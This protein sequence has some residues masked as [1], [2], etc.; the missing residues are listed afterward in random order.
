MILS[1]VPLIVI[2]APSAVLLVGLVTLAITIFLSSTVKMLVFSVVVVP[3]TVRF[4]FTTK[5]PPRLTVLEDIVGYNPIVL[6]FEFITIAF[7]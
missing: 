2:P 7:S 6:A 1:V 4:P 5:S 3:S